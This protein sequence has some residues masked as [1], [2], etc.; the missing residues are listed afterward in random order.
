MDGWTTEYTGQQSRNQIP[1]SLNL[2]YD[3]I[4]TMQK[5]SREGAKA[6]E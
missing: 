6:V 2:R 5:D 3:L 4:Y 1:K